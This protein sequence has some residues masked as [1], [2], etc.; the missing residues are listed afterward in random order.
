M[1]LGNWVVEARNRLLQVPIRG[2]LFDAPGLLS[3]RMLILRAMFKIG[4]GSVIGAHHYF[5]IPHGLPRK[6][7]I[8]GEKS[9]IGHHVEIEHSGGV[10]IGKDVW[11][12]QYTLIETHEHEIGVKPKKQWPLVTEP[13]VIEDGVWIGAKVTVLPGVKRIGRNAIIGA[14]S[15]VTKEVP[16]NA[17]AIGSPARVVRIRAESEPPPTSAEMRE[18]DSVA[19]A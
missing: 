15:I 1:K 13:L 4:K 16:E 9:E 12:S 17:V 10:F 2:F 11:I 7:L 5:A 14:G 6:P 19:N 8:I 3:I 18:L